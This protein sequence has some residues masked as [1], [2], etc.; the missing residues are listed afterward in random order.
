MNDHLSHVGAA[1]TLLQ[2][3]LAL[4]IVAT[5]I[6][7]AYIA[8]IYA[9]QNSRLDANTRLVLLA[10]GILHEAPRPEVVD[11]RTWALDVLA[12]HSDVKIPEAARAS[13]EKATSLPVVIHTEPWEKGRLLLGATSSWGV[14]PSRWCVT[15]SSSKSRRPCSTPAEARNGAGTGRPCC[16][17]GS[18]RR[19]GLASSPDLQVRVALLWLNTPHERRHSCHCEG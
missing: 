16:G 7:T 10:I 2:K 9:D 4:A 19:P 12:A 15:P 13:L 18:P 3:P 17:S 8:G 1:S 6:A 11:I 5:P 14:I